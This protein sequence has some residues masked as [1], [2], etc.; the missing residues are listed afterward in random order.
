MFKVPVKLRASAVVLA[1]LLC[2]AA[3]GCGGDADGAEMRLYVLETDIRELKSEL[4]QTGEQVEQVGEQ[5]GMLF[6]A[7]ADLR[8]EQARM[9]QRVRDLEEQSGRAEVP[10]SAMMPAGILFPGQTAADLTARLEAIQDIAPR[11]TL[12]DGPEYRRVLVE[13]AKS[14]A[15]ASPAAAGL[16]VDLVRK[17]VGLEAERTGSD[18]HLVAMTLSNCAPA[19]LADAAG[20]LA[21]LDSVLAQR[22]AECAMTVGPQP[23]LPAGLMSPVTL[24]LL[25]AAVDAFC[26]AA[27]ES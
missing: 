25:P 22:L 24:A 21:G 7:L 5:Y 12:S 10:A 15:A 26:A 6:D 13:Q 14:C 9:S 1:A 11:F 17:A 16:P 2:A 3:V 23:G 8:L 19:P 20:A 27:G 4:A 18:A